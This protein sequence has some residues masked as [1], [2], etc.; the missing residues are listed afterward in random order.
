MKQSTIIDERTFQTITTLETECCQCHAKTRH[1]AH[2]TNMPPFDK[3]VQFSI[4]GAR[5]GMTFI[6]MEKIV[7]MQAER[8]RD[9]Q[10]SFDNKSAF[11]RSQIET[12]QKVINDFIP[13]TTDYNKE[14]E[15]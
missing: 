13:L 14:S 6:D 5:Q 15:D 2:A 11:L 7:Q 3:G 9:M 10:N 8:M 4:S 1:V 12:L